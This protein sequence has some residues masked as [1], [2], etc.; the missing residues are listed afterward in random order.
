M[1][2][3]LSASTVFSRNNEPPVMF[4]TM[5]SDKEIIESIADRLK[6]EL[7]DEQQLLPAEIV[8]KLFAVE[9]AE[10]KLKRG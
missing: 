1:F 6:D 2:V 10:A 3:A 7:D 4:G 5:D 8:E 9:A